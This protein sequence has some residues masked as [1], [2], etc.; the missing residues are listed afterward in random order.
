VTFLLRRKDKSTEKDNGHEV[1]RTNTYLEIVEANR[2][3]EVGIILTF[4]RNPTDS[5][6]SDLN[7]T[8]NKGVE[9]IAI[10]SFSKPNKVT[11]SADH[12]TKQSRDCS[13]KVENGVISIMPLFSNSDPYSGNVAVVV[14]LAKGRVSAIVKDERITFDVISFALGE[15][16]KRIDYKHNTVPLLVRAFR[17]K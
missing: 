3:G 15:E 5:E 2:V 12:S 17:R 13:I 6:E 16:L 8:V 14:D 11:A 4:L 9:Y 7:I 1:E 10:I